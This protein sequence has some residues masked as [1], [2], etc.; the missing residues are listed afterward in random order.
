MIRLDITSLFI[1][2]NRLKVAARKLRLSRRLAT[3]EAIR[4]KRLQSDPWKFCHLVFSCKSEKAI[5][6]SR[7]PAIRDGLKTLNASL[8]ASERLPEGLWND[9]SSPLFCIC[10]GKRL[11]V[12]FIGPG[13]KGTGLYN[14][15]EQIRRMLESVVQSN[16]LK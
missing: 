9:R 5:K 15:R 3:P 12:V 2:A 16:L 11:H 4:Q 8:P 14:K 10:G 6:L 1:N 13:R 7:A